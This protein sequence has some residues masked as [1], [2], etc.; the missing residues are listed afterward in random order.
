MRSAF[1]ET[2]LSPDRETQNRSLEQLCEGL[3]LDTL[4]GECAAL[5]QFRRETDNLYHRVRALFYLYALYRFELPARLVQQVPG[6]ISAAGHEHFLNRRF[7]EAIEAFQVS[8]KSQLTDTICSALAAGYY[9]LGLQFLANQ[10]R[11]SV[12]SVRGNQ[13]MFRTGRAADHPLKF[14]EELLQ[15]SDGLYPVLR[16][17]TAVRMD[18]THSSWSDI[19][20]LGMDYPEAAKVINV[21]VDLA[22]RGRDQKPKPPIEIYLRVIDQPVIQLVSVDLGAIS[23]IERLEE[24][25]DFAK[26]YNGLLKAALIAAGIVP[27]GLEGSPSELSELLA[28]LVGAGRGI[29][30]VSSV[31]NIPK[32]SRLA[33][34]TNLLAGLISVCMRATGQSDALTG[35]LE[36]SDRRV[37]AARAI[38]GEWL[39]G[40]GGGWQDSG[41]I[42]P[43]IKA[44]SGAESG[45]GDPELG[46]SRGRLMPTHQLI[47]NDEVS[48]ETRQK[49]QDSLVLV[50]GGMAQNVGPILEMVTEKYL[51]RSAEE[52]SARHQ[53]LSLFDEVLAALRCGDIRQL[54]R[55]TTEH[56]F[57]PLQTI[58][59]W[60]TTY[61]TERLIERVRAEFGDQ[62]WGFW[63]LGGMSGGGMGFIVDPEIKERA[64]DRI[65]IILAETKGQLEKALPFAMEPVVYD[66]AINERGTY[67][68]LLEGENALLAPGYYPLVWPS[69]L[70]KDV[71][72]IEPSKR[73]ELAFFQARLND[74]AV[75]QEAGKALFGNLFPQVETTQGVEDDLGCLLAENGFDVEQHERIREQLT[76]GAIGMAMNRLPASTRVEDVQPGDVIDAAHAATEQDRVMGAAAIANGEVAV[77]SLAAGA[78]SRWTL[79]AGVVKAINPF[80]QFDGRH[81]SFLE[82]HLAKSNRTGVEHGMAPGHV[83]TTSYLTHDPI[84]SFLAFEKNYGFSGPLYLSRGKSIG[85]RMVPME[86]DLRF[87]WEELSHQVLD[88]RA[89]KM[90]ES[91]HGALIQW[92]KATGEGSDYRDNL[93][94]QCLHPVGHWYEI[95][96]LLLNGTLLSLLRERP[97]LRTILMHNIDTLGASVDPAYLG[98]HR[99]T[100]AAISFEV[101]ARRVED[102]GGGL[103]RVDGR[104]RLVEGLAL[105]REEDELKLSYYNTLTNWI[106]VDALLS[107]FGLSR[108]DLEDSAKVA[109]AVR[110]FALQMPTYITIKDVKKRWGHGQED[111]FPVSQFERLWGDMSAVPDFP[112]AFFVVPRARGQQLK[113]PAQ[114][115]GWLRD[116][117]RDYVASLCRWGS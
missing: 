32:G 53:S 65:Q 99:R 12:R 16:E 9:Q 58:I 106:E 96:N 75:Y 74:Q 86:R 64:R 14:R 61:Y 56:F 110:E 63:M 2:I 101:I 116:G 25:F 46:V 11:H 23:R 26:D 6:H 33:V 4:R 89:Q 108:S 66:F 84:A 35:P 50:H 94:L 76:K 113:D 69:L 59:P 79:G 72:S 24:V 5:D 43:G 30:L 49:L 115:D 107:R 44:I 112:A 22:V 111:V 57:G 41:G 1:V 100:G 47:D 73:A 77:V 19:F 92:A 88:E 105:P 83:F 80:A 27:I 91:L 82:I 8:A 85:L 109:A 90:R 10:V 36:E 98:L 51:L 54:G 37:A 45:P 17:D 114:L 7:H 67:C 20:F 97:N 87:A 48:D 104:V 3:D 21:S 95:P 81:R 52:W 34:S 60:C 55:L 28:Q 31:N 78:G 71:R 18:L 103:A 117:S 40:S 39:G 42:W 68:Q 29:E 13:W 15:P 62:F 38:L 70:R 93:A 102:N